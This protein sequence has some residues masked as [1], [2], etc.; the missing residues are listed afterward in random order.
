MTKDRHDGR[1]GRCGEACAVCI[2]SAGADVIAR[3]AC[4]AG[5]LPCRTY[6]HVK[7]Q[8]CVCRPALIVET[9]KIADFNLCTL[10]GCRGFSVRRRHAPARVQFIITKEISRREIDGVSKKAQ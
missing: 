2:V 4:D 9:S 7:L 5:I 3:R 8:V 10:A 6:D 1:S